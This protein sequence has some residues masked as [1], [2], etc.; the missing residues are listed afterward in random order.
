MIKSSVTV[1]CTV[2][3]FEKMG[4]SNLLMGK[5]LLD[6]VVIGFFGCGASFE[7]LEKVENT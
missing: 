3:K 1:S 7:R 6:L 5:F 2:I 4:E